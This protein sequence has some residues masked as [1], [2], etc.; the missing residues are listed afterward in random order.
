MLSTQGCFIHDGH[1]SDN[2]GGKMSSTIVD[3]TNFILKRSSWFQFF[4]TLQQATLTQKQTL[5]ITLLH[6]FDLIV[7]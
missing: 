2:K 1:K 5:E 4:C 7:Y 6:P 3:L